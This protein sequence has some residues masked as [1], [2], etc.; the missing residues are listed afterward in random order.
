MVPLES[1]TADDGSQREPLLWRP[2]QGCKYSDYL[3]GIAAN[4]AQSRIRRQAIPLHVVVLGNVPQEGIAHGR[5]GEVEYF[6]A[7]FDVDFERLRYLSKA[8]DQMVALGAVKNIVAP[9]AHD[10]FQLGGVR[11]P[12]F[13]SSRNAA[14]SWS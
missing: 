1:L 4:R 3:A 12:S 11:L 6:V 7:H 5:I 8:Q 10:G 9:L 2:I 14:L 13:T